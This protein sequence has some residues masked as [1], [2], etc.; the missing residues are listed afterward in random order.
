MRVFSRMPGAEGKSRTSAGTPF[1]SAAQS[2][3]RLSRFGLCGGVLM[4]ARSSI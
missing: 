3:V 4:L 1:R 2:F